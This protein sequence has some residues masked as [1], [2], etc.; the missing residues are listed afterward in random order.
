[1]IPP[2]P[3]FRPGF[4]PW[5]AAIVGVEPE[6]MSIHDLLRSEDGA[7][8]RLEAGYGALVA[9]YGA[10]LPVELGTPATRV[11]WGR[12]GVRVET[13]RGNIE[14]RA[15]VVTVSTSVLAAGRIRFD[16]PLPEGKVEAFHGVPLGEACKTALA[17]ERNVFDRAQ[18]FFL[19]FAEGPHVALHFEIRPFGRDLA[20][21]HLGGRWARAAEAAGAAAMVGLALEALVDVFGSDVRRRLRASATTAW[22]GDPDVL[23]GYSCALPGKAHLRPRLAEPVGE[24]L[25]FAGEAC[26]IRHFGTVHG[27]WETGVAAARRVAVQLGHS[28]GGTPFDGRRTG[29]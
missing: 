15:A 27:A 12:R 13:A 28:A 4:E 1:M 10:G 23:G 21:A 7:N 25:F 3:R 18:P 20:V 29:V 11:R 8:W 5:F 17:F 9:H 6:R 24:R 26:S 22:I 2:D 14:A 19:G 16:P